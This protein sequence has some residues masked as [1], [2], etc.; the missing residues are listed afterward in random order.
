MSVSFDVVTA[1]SDSD[2]SQSREIAAG[3]LAALERA[4][5]ERDL[6]AAAGLFQAE[7]WWRDHL[8]FTW[9][10]RTF[11]GTQE[12]EGALGDALDALAQTSFV[13]RPDWEPEQMDAMAPYDPW[14]QA[15][16]EYSNPLSR[17]RGVLRLTEQD[18]VYKALMFSTQMVELVD[19]PET[20]AENRPLG[21]S[22]GEQ[23]SRRTWIE[24]RE[25]DLEFV[26][27]EPQV[28]I[29]GAGHSG[30]ALAARL[31]R[32]GVK[33]LLV[34]RNKRVGDN[35]R[36]RFRAL[37]L[38][39]P[40]FFNHMPYIPFPK[41][42]PKYDPKDKFG[43]WLESY[44]TS[45]E[46][47]VWTSAEFLGGH[48]D[49]DLGQWTVRVRREDGHVRTLHPHHMVLATG[50]QGAP[51]IPDIPGADEFQGEVW[52]SSAHGTGRDF[53]GKKALVVGA[54][55]SAHD[56]AHDFYEQGASEVTLL[57]R[58]GTH[59]LSSEKGYMYMLAG[60]YEE[61][62]PDVEDADLIFS[63]IPYKPFLE[64]HKGLTEH[65]ATEFDAEMVD[66]LRKVGYNVVFGDKWDDG[67]FKRWL[68]RGG[69]YYIE[70]GAAQLI[71]EGKI[72]VKQGTQIERFTPHGVV[73]ADGT[74][75]DVD[76]VVF[77]TGW[78]NMRE[79]ARALLGD[80]VADQVSSDIGGLDDEGELRIQ[81]RRSGH[82]NLWFMPGAIFE[83][84]PHSR[85]VALQIKAI[86]EGIIPR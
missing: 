55:N 18:G 85:Y 73:F 10:L 16:F 48:Y 51:Q 53:V 57:Q 21:V 9:D 6:E 42:W 80:K 11:H 34:E 72:K 68:Y 27:S 66:G 70:V 74:E 15:L 63:S 59:V 67:F 62:G 64:I 83:A 24:R 20:V 8:A 5:R 76:V 25:N 50:A 78:T 65:I 3:W 81:W 60:L 19:F 36:N 37:V 84:R 61:N 75:M 32:L 45:M 23:R 77:A 71:I 69:G 47:N 35:W 39:S 4:C 38:H 79:T 41:S 29:I 26:D 86:E 14:I 58:S 46:L 49:E 44:A 17:G 1:G 31:G 54:G 56:I 28:L 30:L 40:V 33:T 2:G 22:H 12:I 13:L 7:G 82:E 52:H 43:G